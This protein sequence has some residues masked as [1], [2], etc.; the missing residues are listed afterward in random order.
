MYAALEI[1]Y[2]ESDQ[3]PT[4]EASQNAKKVGS[5]SYLANDAVF[6]VLRTGFGVESRRQKVERANRSSC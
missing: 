2:H 5:A 4:G 6:D 1:D 3:D